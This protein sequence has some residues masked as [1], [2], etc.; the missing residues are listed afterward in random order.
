MTN[1]SPRDSKR[2]TENPKSMANVSHVHPYADQGAMTRVFNRGP[3]ATDGGK[4]AESD[5]SQEATD[6]D[7][8]DENESETMSDVEHTPP[9]GAGDADSVF[10]RGYEKQDEDR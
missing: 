9:K 7:E 6:A 1:E 3:V 4:V 5:D 8:D 2:R 10:E